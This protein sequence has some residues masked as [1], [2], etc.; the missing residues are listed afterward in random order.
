MSHIV[1]K[2]AINIFSIKKI[3][4]P[5]GYLWGG[6]EAAVAVCVRPNPNIVPHASMMTNYFKILHDAL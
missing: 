2:F 6:G 5:N 4:F 1:H 3:I